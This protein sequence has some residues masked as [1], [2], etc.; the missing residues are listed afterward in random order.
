LDRWLLDEL[1]PDA[2]VIPFLAIVGDEL[3]NE[4]PK[5]PLAQGLKQT[6]AYKLRIAGAHDRIIAERRGATGHRAG[7]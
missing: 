1:V 2:L 4:V 7:V 5:V 3:A 6:I